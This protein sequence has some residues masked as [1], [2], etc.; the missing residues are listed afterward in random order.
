MILVMAMYLK[1]LERGIDSSKLAPISSQLLRLE[2]E[3]CTVTQVEIDEVLRL[4][5]IVSTSLVKVKHCQP[6]V[7]LTVCDEAAEV[8]ANNAMPCCA[9]PLIKLYLVNTSSK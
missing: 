5:A 2:E 3:D 8:P 9:L 7:I 1:S 6:K 4:C